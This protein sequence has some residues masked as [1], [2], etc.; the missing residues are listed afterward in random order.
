MLK[1]V[2]R[3]KKDTGYSTDIVI[4]NIKIFNTNIV[5]LFNEVLS[6]GETINN[7]ILKPL[8]NFV[9]ENKKSCDLYSDLFSILSANN[10]VEV[11]SYNSLIDYIYKGF[12]ILIINNK[13]MGVE[14]KAPLTRSIT[15]SETESSITGPKEAFVED[16]NK[17]IGLIRKRIRNNKLYVSK[18]Y[19]GKQSNTLVGLCYMNNIVNKELVLKI[20]N[21]LKSINVDGVIDS[22]NIRD[23]LVKKDSFLPVVNST[24]RP[25]LV[26]MAL[27]EGKVA[28]VVDNSPYVLILPSFFVD[29]FHT[30][31]DYYQKPI[32]IT[33][34][35]IVRLLAFIVAIFLPALYI[36][37]TT[38][39]PDAIP[40]KILIN[41]SSQRMSVPFPSFIE[42]LFLILSFEILRESDTRIPSK[43]GTSV[44]ILGGLVLG[45]AAV[46]AGI[47][48][49]IMIIVIA[50]SSIS[51][52][53]FSNMSLIYSIR[54]FRLIALFISAFFGIYGVFISLVL[55]LTKL[56][57]IDSFGY[58][59]MAPLSPVVKEELRDSFIRTKKKNKLR[60]P[61]LTKNIIREKDYD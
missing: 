4:R 27:L 59:Y 36:S 53:V 19:I 8:S 40:V 47:I 24:E 39:N 42:A 56:C 18:M 29:F 37:V 20:K 25:D 17:N 35:R 41:F 61:I 60:N 28:I 22:G 13:V 43:M 58:P 5:M 7:F 9:L 26:S 55:L 33:F 44:S 23:K 14:T 11:N 52:L 16:F 34:I 51:G 50:I 48:S 49:P 32:N 54:Y 6:D 38:L 46:N 31:D 1:L 15:V 57:S 10:I 12:T 45:D 30:A 3:I 2:K 21:M